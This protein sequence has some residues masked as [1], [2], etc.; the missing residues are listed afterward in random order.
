[1]CHG[2]AIETER[3]SGRLVRYCRARPDKSHHQVR[4]I[5]PPQTARKAKTKAK[6]QSGQI[7]VGLAA[8][9]SPKDLLLNFLPRTLVSGDRQTAGIFAVAPWVRGGVN[10]RDLEC[11]FLRLASVA[12]LTEPTRAE[13]IRCTFSQACPAA[14][15][16]KEKGPKMLARR[17][18]SPLATRLHDSLMLTF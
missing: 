10:N 18:S 3:K 15:S 4:Y 2:Q 9:C 16:E 6:D 13:G 8:T 5:K 14:H 1:M 7:R 11:V 12:L 17:P